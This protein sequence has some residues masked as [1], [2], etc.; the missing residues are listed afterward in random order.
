MTR[1][2]TLTRKKSIIASIM[3]VY[4]YVQ[5]GEPYD[6]ELDGIPLRLVDPPLKNGKTITF[7]VP[8]FELYLYVIFDKRRPKG[9]NTNFLLPAGEEDIQLY[10][11]PQY[12]PF[13]GN[14]FRIYE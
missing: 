4:I 2:I 8:T 1:K 10:T 3:K 5:S 13:A 11:K 6:I 12:N 7:E 14:P 9:Y